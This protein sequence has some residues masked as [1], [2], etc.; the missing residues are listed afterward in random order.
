MRLKLFLSVVMPV[1]NWDQYVEEAI[2]RILS[3]SIADVEFIIDDGS[4]RISGG[5]L[6]NAMNSDNGVDC[7]ESRYSH[8][9][10][11]PQSFWGLQIGA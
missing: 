4:Y 10:L 6:A 11:L 9:G 2:D 3:Q 5:P 1:Y 8:L 7:A